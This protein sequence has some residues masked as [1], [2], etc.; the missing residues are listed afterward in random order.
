[1]PVQ[2]ERP[3][4]VGGA[5]G[6]TQITLA[7]RAQWLG[8]VSLT[9]ERGRGVLKAL[10]ASILAL[11]RATGTNRVGGQLSYIVYSNQPAR[12]G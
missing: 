8:I 1:M 6:S 3:T 9:S 2:P 11:R 5:L 12:T 7:S 4:Y 10:A